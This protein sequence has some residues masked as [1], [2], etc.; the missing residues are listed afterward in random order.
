MLGKVIL[1]VGQKFAVLRMRTS[2]EY[3]RLEEF[4]AVTMKNAVF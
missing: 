2:I 1:S 3:V 4:T